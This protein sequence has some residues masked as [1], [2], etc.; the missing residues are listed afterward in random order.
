MNLL[1]RNCCPDCPQD[2]PCEDCFKEPPHPCPRGTG[3]CCPDA[4]Q[5]AA[6]TR[7]VQWVWSPYILFV[8]GKAEAVNA[9]D[10]HEG[11]RGTFY[12][13][14]SR[15]YTF[16]SPKR[17]GH[18]YPQCCDQE[19]NVIDFE[20]NFWERAK[21]PYE[22]YLVY[23][24]I[25]LKDFLRPENSTDNWTYGT[26]TMH[27]DNVCN[28]TTMVQCTPLANGTFPIETLNTL[29]GSKLSGAGKKFYANRNEYIVV[30]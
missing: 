8:Q 21:C 22:T 11:S 29:E 2:S 14:K 25:E 10:V 24:R 23:E 15:E 19:G 4:P 5:R 28:C 17:H 13:R 16:H 6:I 27:H 7:V 12:Y 26:F 18:T 1:P 3:R 20:E 9:S 30:H